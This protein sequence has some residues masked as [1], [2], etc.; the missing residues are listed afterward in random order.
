[1]GGALTISLYILIILYGA[2]KL[3]DMRD[4]NT[5]IQR[6]FIILDSFDQSNKLNLYRENFR[7]AFSFEGENDQE[8]KDNEDYVKIMARFW[9]QKNSERTEIILKHH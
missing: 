6:D 8:L 3:R 9:N 4:K 1:M 2:S 5:V 7:L